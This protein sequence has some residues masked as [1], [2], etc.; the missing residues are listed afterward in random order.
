MTCPRAHRHEAALGTS[1]VSMPN[2]SASPV[3]CMPVAPPA[4]TR[5]KS[6][7]S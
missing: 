5:A 3:M 7:G 1:T 6:R 2:S 4:H